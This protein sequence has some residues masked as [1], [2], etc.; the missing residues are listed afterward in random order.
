MTEFIAI[1][2]QFLA[3]MTIYSTPL[4]VP[5]SPSGLSC[6]P[7]YV[8]IPA[9]IEAVTPQAILPLLVETPFVPSPPPPESPLGSE[10]IKAAVDAIEAVHN[11]VSVTSDD[12][13]HLEGI[14]PAY[15]SPPPSPSFVLTPSASSLPPTASKIAVLNSVEA[16][17]DRECDCYSWPG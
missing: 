17:L 3:E 6:P 13:E 5:S 9:E 15:Q 16:R 1:L 8:R 10:E 11:S 14:D 2:D 4:T 7:L 12:D